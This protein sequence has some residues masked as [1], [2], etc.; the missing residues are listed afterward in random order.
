MALG[1]FQGELDYAEDSLFQ[2]GLLKLKSETRERKEILSFSDFSTQ[3]NV[4]EKRIY[5]YS[6]GN[7]CF[8]RWNGKI[9]RAKEGKCDSDIFAIEFRMREVISTTLVGKACIWQMWQCVC[10]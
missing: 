2:A 5:I 9:Y 10:L 6:G 8:R 1:D 7:M 3:V 4:G